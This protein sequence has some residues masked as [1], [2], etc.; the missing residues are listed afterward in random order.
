MYGKCQQR[1][2]Q[3]FQG[4]LVWSAQVVWEKKKKSFDLRDEV[5]CRISTGGY[6]EPSRVML[7]LSPISP[8]QPMLSLANISAFNQLIITCARERNNSETI[9]FGVGIKCAIFLEVH[10]SYLFWIVEADVKIHLHFPSTHA[11]AQRYMAQH[12]MVLGESHTR[13]KK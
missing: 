12:W 11:R 10:L 13:I 2:G 6:T 5:L 4:S 9:C 1:R 8:K 3:R 7:I